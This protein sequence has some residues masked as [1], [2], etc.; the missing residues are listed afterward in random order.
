MRRF[1]RIALFGQTAELAFVA[2]PHVS[3]FETADGEHVN[4]QSNSD[5]R[6]GNINAAIANAYDIALRYKT[7]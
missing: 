4:Q 6:I 5:G 7:A 2:P 3:N 1:R